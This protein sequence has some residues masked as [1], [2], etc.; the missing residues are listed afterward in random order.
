MKCW[1]K[2]LLAQSGK[3]QLIKSI[4]FGKQTYWAQVFILPKKIMKLINTHCGIFLWIGHTCPSKRALVSREK[5]YIP[6]AVG[7]QNILNIYNQNKVG[8]AKKLWTLATKANSIWKKWVHTYY[9]KGASVQDRFSPKNTSWIVKKVNESRKVIMLAPGL[10][11]NLQAKLRQLIVK[12]RIS[13]K[14][15]YLAMLPDLPKVP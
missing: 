10:Q 11:G 13:I 5:L 6:N 14:K 7:G 2:K 8:V 9:I 12:D 15:L 4:V 1:S 3:I